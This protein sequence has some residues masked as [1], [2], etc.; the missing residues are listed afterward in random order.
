GITYAD[1][2]V[3]DIHVEPLT[4]EARESVLDG[5]LI[6][7]ATVPDRHKD[8]HDSVFFSLSFIHPTSA[9]PHYVYDR[10]DQQD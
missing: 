9:S 7:Q 5:D 6:R 10:Y 2:V 8:T 1:E 3:A 4:E